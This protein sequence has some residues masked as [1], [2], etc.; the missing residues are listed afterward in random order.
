LKLIMTRQAARDQDSISR[1]TLERWGHR[2]VGLY[3]GGLVEIFEVLARGETV[4]RCVATLP[5][6]YLRVAYEA[7]FIFYTR[8]ET[9]IRIVRILHQRMDHARHLS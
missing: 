7:H 8:N 3:V 1:F 2:Q 4:G 6:K 9:S 5:S